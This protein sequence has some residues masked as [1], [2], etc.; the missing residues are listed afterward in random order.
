MWHII[1]VAYMWHST[2]RYISSYH[3]IPH[4]KQ[5]CGP[6][7]DI[8]HHSTTRRPCW[9]GKSWYIG[10]FCVPCWARR[11]RW[12]VASWTRGQCWWA[13]WFHRIWWFLGC[14]GSWLFCWDL[15]FFLG[16]RIP[17]W[18]GGD[19]RCCWAG[20]GPGEELKLDRKSN[21]RTIVGAN[22]R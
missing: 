1:F 18:S 10:I 7:P 3:P 5:V 22:L 8:F 4:H 21:D 11:T 12:C 20:Q 16:W 2:P 14:L 17:G 15:S 19:L 13:W 6:S 9:Q